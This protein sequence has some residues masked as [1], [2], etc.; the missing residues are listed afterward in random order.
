MHFAVPCCD[1]GGF[2]FSVLMWNRGRQKGKNTTGAA[3]SCVPSEKT[4]HKTSPGNGNNTNQDQTCFQIIS[5]SCVFLVSMIIIFCALLATCCMIWTIHHPFSCHRGI[6]EHAHRPPSSPSLRTRFF[7]PSLTQ[8]PFRPVCVSLKTS[9]WSWSIRTRYASIISFFMIPANVRRKY[10]MT[11]GFR[12]EIQGSRC[13]SH[14]GSY[15]CKQENPVRRRVDMY[16]HAK[17][18][19]C[20]FM[21]SVCTDA[22]LFIYIYISV[23]VCGGGIKI[24]KNEWKYIDS[25][26]GSC[27]ILLL[28]SLTFW[29]VWGSYI[30]PSAIA[31]SAILTHGQYCSCR[32]R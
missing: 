19:K 11:F 23:C 7:A 29:Q 14:L 13:K 1:A 3:G 24:Y 8:K 21:C 9:L 16:I 30:S 12:E 6:G 26:Y 25:P 15:S 17:H 18:A 10:L 20:A 5:L 27:F 4:H 32:K 2:F 28:I 22:F 31:S